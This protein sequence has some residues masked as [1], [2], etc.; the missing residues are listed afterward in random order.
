MTGV[1]K[2]SHLSPPSAF[3]AATDVAAGLSHHSRTPSVLSLPALPPLCP[4]HPG[5][6]FSCPA[7]ANPRLGVSRASRFLVLR[8]EEQ[9]VGVGQRRQQTGGSEQ[10]REPAVRTE[11]EDRHADGHFGESLK[12]ECRGGRRRVGTGDT[13]AHRCMTSA[14]I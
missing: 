5:G 2:L 13:P 9:G 3:D 8:K 7:R 12:S 1:S 4:A 14:T 6:L 10:P 11:R